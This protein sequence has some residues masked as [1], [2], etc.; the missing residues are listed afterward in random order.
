M[1]PQ[2]ICFFWTQGEAAAPDL[3]RRCWEA[4]AAMNPDWEVAV[5]DARDA[6]KAFD[7]QGI[8]HPPGTI[9][10][11][12]DIFRLHWLCASGGVYID[13]A[14]VPVRPL[15]DWIGPLAST[16]FFAFHDPFRRRPVE[17]WFLV[18]TPDHPITK[19]WMTLTRAYWQ[20]PRRAQSR[21]RELDPGPKGALS[22]R[23]AGLSAALTGPTKAK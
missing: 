7:A 8:A 4:W 22:C 16:G 3:V 17:N 23:L 10:G 20:R 13:A 14:T 11:Q 18:S 5:F 6:Q 2:R 21:R 15:S 19:G 1:L 12:A 9:Q